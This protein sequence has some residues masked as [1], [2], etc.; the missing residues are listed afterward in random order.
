MQ[1]NQVKI[2]ITFGLEFTRDGERISA[3]RRAV[4]LTC[5]TNVA[6]ALFEG[7]TL[8]EGSGGW[9][10]KPEMKGL[11]EKGKL[12]TEKTATIILYAERL[13]E[14][15]PSVVRTIKDTLVQK[16]VA[17]AITPVNFNIR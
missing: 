8:H 1:T 9:L 10:D 7:Y 4:G 12:V 11:G 16:C 3:T 13:D 5:I 6:V 2:E 17:V 14:R 15:V